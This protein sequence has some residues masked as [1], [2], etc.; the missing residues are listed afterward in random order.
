M[1][2]LTEHAKQILR[3]IADGKQ[4]EQRSVNSWQAINIEDVLAYVIGYTD[5]SVE[6]NIRIKPETRSINGVK[7][8]APNGDVNKGHTFT[9]PQREQLRT[10][11]WES[12]LDVDTAF[13]TI[14]DALEG[15]TK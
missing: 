14:I 8:A 3:A 5:K 6:E 4:I 11:R 12:V 15:V 7:F 2:Q 1:T 13:N 9:M 10:F